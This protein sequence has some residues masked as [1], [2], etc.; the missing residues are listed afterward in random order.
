MRQRL[1]TYD[2]IFA[3]MIDVMSLSYLDD[4]LIYSDNIPNTSSRS[5]KYVWNSHLSAWAKRSVSAESSHFSDVSLCSG[6]VV[7]VDEDVVQID[8]DMTSIMSAKMSFHKPLERPLRISK[9]FRHYT[10]P[11]DP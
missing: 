10:T 11:K 6:N 3:D 7:R 4:I 9:P 5:E 2:D 8:N 1:P